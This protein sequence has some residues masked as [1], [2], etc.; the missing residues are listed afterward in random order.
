MKK[1]LLITHDKTSF[2]DKDIKIFNKLRADHIHIDSNIKY[3]IN[4]IFTLR[5]YDMIFV[6]FANWKSLLLSVM[7]KIKKYEVYIFICGVDCN[8]TKSI[9]NG[10]FSMSRLSLTRLSA[11]F[12]YKLCTGLLPKWHTMINSINEYTGDIEGYSNYV[13]ETINKTC[14]IP[15]GYDR[16]IWLN[17]NIDR[18][19]D[20]LMVAHAKNLKKIKLKGID[21]FVR[22][23][24]LLSNYKFR[25]IGVSEEFLKNNNIVLTK[26]IEAIGQLENYQLVYEYNRSINICLLSLSEGMPNVLFEA[27]LCGCKPIITNIP[28]AKDILIDSDRILKSNDDNDIVNTFIHSINSAKSDIL[29]INIEE[30]T[31]NRRKESI[32]NIIYG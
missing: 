19:I 6:H 7:G 32:G 9:K 14:I 27:M 13:S 28:I 5:K 26:N 20:F 11:T 31:I 2:I 18:N 8:S 29:K 3:L 16:R 17:K 15:N 4:V 30:F 24:N 22:A 23:A 10:V 12:A 21:T 25:L 1:V